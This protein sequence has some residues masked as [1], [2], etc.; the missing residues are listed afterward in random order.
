M[1]ASPIVNYSRVASSQQLRHIPPHRHA[2]SNLFPQILPFVSDVWGLPSLP[3]YSPYH[4]TPI[5]TTLT[6]KLTLLSRA[7]ACLEE[8]DP[9]EIFRPVWRYLWWE[10]V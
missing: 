8:C 7:V 10:M 4:V 6:L 1:L 3:V 9:V 5:P 2:C